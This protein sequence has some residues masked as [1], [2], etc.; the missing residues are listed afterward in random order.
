MKDRRLLESI[1]HP[2]HILFQ[3]LCFLMVFHSSDK[4]KHHKAGSVC[5]ESAKANKS[6]EQYE[7]AKVYFLAS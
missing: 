1:I 4:N 5:N 2:V 6:L 3:Q 7:L